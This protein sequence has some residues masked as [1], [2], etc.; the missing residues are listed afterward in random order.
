MHT[1]DGLAVPDLVLHGVPLAQPHVAAISFYSGDWPEGYTFAG[2][3]GF[4]GIS[5]SYSDE[6]Y[7]FKPN[8]AFLT[9]PFRWWWTCA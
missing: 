9:R 1:A 6:Y 2:R 7:L 4:V 8:T 5:R 3:V